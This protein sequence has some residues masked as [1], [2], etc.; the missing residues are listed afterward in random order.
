MPPHRTVAGLSPDRIAAEALALVDSKGLES[1]QMRSLADRLGVAQ[2]ALYK[3]VPSKDALLDAVLERVLADFDTSPSPAAPW[4]DR[5]EE[6]AHRFR[7]VLHAHPGLAVLLKSHD[8]LGENST[9]TVDAWAS[10][11]LDAG[12][13]GDEAGHAWFTLVH[14][15]IGFEATGAFEGRNLARASD[16]A[17][18]AEVHARF[19]GLDPDRFPGAATLGAH[20]WTP[21]VEQRFDYGLG[22]ILDGLALRL[23]RIRDE[24]QRD[25]KQR[26]GRA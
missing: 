25:A 21:A 20:I 11:L 19:A 5:L 12:L 22:L 18:L 7:A 13:T 24:D 23:S 15:V 1:L 17:A 3:H 6:L 26:Q 2:S 14:Y 16:P 4:R 9:R 10:A 8:P